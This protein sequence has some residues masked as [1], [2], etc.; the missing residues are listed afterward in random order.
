MLLE[1]IESP[2]AEP[3]TREELLAQ[4]RID[5]D[6]ELD[7]LDRLIATAREHAETVT[8]RS[9]LRQTWQLTLDAFPSGALIKLPRGPV[10]E[11]LSVVCITPAG[12]EQ[13]LAGTDWRVVGGGSLVPR[14]VPAVGHEWPATARTWGAVQITYRTGWESAADVPEAIRHAILML[15]AHWFE[16]RE[17]VSE[18]S[19]GDGMMPVPQAVDSLLAPHVVPWVA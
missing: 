2:I 10:H 4:S 17:A 7:L 1:R 16:H 18:V 6:G 3:V 12:V 8:G 13:S 15:A 5:D 14:L 9:L 19:S 11:V